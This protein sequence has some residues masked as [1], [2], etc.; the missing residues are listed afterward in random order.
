[1]LLYR[2]WMDGEFNPVFSSSF[3]QPVGVRMC[4]GNADRVPVGCIC[5]GTARREPRPPEREPGCG[6][7]SVPFDG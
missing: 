1:M 4:S 2:L 5:L 3:F 7:K 6:L